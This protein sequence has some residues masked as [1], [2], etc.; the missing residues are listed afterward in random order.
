LKGPARLPRWGPRHCR[1][2]TS[3]QYGTSRSRP[4]SPQRN[5][6][7]PPARRPRCR[8]A[9]SGFISCSRVAANGAAPPDAEPHPRDRRPWGEHRVGL[10]ADRTRERGYE[11]GSTQDTTISTRLSAQKQGRWPAGNDSGAARATETAC[12]SRREQCRCGWLVRTA[13]PPRAFLLPRDR[14]SIRSHT[15]RCAGT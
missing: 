3:E 1:T 14:R 8:K 15:G 6:A 13:A 4:Q 2:G 5:R 7:N 9:R 11:T 10:F 12:P